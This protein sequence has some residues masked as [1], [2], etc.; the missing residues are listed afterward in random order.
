MGAMHEVTDETKQ[1]LH[2]KSE[3]QETDKDQADKKGQQP[4]FR[5]RAAQLGYY[6]HFKL[7]ADATERLSAVLEKLGLP[8][9][10]AF[11]D[12]IV[13][14]EQ[15]ASGSFELGLSRPVTL[16]M[17]EAGRLTFGTSVKGTAGDDRLEQLEGVTLE[18]PEVNGVVEKL[19]VDG[20][21]VIADAGFDGCHTASVQS[22]K[23]KGAVL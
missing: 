18:S 4:D 13:S 3:E 11:R 20:D 16:P 21:D 6:S 9:A 19:V 17:G 7:K 23:V 8:I 1:A 22:M 5:Q 2:A 12:T 10:S 15:E 14:F